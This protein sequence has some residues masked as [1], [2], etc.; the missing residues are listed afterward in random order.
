MFLFIAGMCG[1]LF[2]TGIIPGKTKKNDKKKWARKFKSEVAKK[3]S[4]PH[5]CGAYIY[6]YMCIWKQH[7]SSKKGEQVLLIIKFYTGRKQRVC[8][9]VGGGLMRTKFNKLLSLLQ[10]KR[11]LLTGYYGYYFI[12]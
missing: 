3:F 5:T 4:I 10:N 11:Q 7:V 1:L 9:C 8:V 12:I 6:R 2:M